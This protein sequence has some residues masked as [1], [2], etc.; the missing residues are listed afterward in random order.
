MIEPRTCYF[1]TCDRCGEEFDDNCYHYDSR[2]LE[3]SARESE[4]KEIGGKWY[5]PDCYY[6]DDDDEIKVRDN[7]I[8]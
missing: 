5:C 1:L 6:Y 3:F 2:T 8:H 4:W 7:E